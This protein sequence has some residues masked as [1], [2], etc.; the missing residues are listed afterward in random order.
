ME[1]INKFKLIS[2]ILLIINSNIFAQINN[3]TNTL[4]NNSSSTGNANNGSG[5]YSFSNGTG[6]ITIGANSA[7]IGSVNT[8]SG[9]NSLAL[10][11]N[12]SSSGSNSITFG[13]QNTASNSY[14]L[15][16]GYKSISSGAYGISLG[17][18][19][20]AESIFSL[21]IGRYVKSS[22]T[23]SHVIGTGNNASY[24]L[25]NNIPNS[26]MIGYNSN[27]PTLFISPSVGNNQI[28]KVGIGTTNVNCGSN[29]DGYS[30]FVIGG[31]KTELITVEIASTSGWADYV[32]EEDYKLPSLFE[33]EDFIK[34][35]KHLPG[36]PSSEEVHANG[37]DLAK[38]DA[39]LLKK[40]EEL[41][42]YII[43]QQKLIKQLL[44]TK[45]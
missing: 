16:G 26:L 8:T 13:Y 11:S 31:I 14:S 29:C 42:L 27:I 32:F 21:S 30:L 9:I 19:S 43:E 45:N 44:D 3:G 18:F 34:K 17:Y 4:N 12:N 24:Y 38:M 22:N 6:N 2:S 36:V 28:G 33:I 1:I 23:N 41:T 40:I 39:T 5:P 15:S 37:I 7:G 35:N 25:D 10:G 20:K